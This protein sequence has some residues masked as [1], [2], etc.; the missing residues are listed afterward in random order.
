[1]LSDVRP[2]VCWLKTD[3]VAI[4]SNEVCVRLIIYV[5][6]LRIYFNF[7]YALDLNGDAYMDEEY[8]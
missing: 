5:N 1:M 2:H 7:S 8:V 3:N 6:L 4:I